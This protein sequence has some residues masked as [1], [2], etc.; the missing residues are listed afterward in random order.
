MKAKLVLLLATCLSISAC[1]SSNGANGQYDAVTSTHEALR[2]AAQARTRAQLE[3]MTPTGTLL[4]ESRYDACFEY[5]RNWKIQ[6]PNRIECHLHLT[7]AVAVPNVIEAIRETRRRFAAAGCPNDAAFEDS[8]RYYTEVNGADANDGYKRNVD[9]PQ[10]L[11]DCGDARVQ[12][13]LINPAAD[14]LEQDF[15]NIDAM[16]GARRVALVEQ[17]GYD[18]AEVSAA[19]ATDAPLVVLVAVDR[20]YFNEGW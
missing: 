4:G 13:Q 10:V 1:V 15:A 17:Q 18:A 5:Q 9:L 7:R 12:A 11:F 6:D 8:L 3:A 2:T 19:R 14:M 20:R 16:I